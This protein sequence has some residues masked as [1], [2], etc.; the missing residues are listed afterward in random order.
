MHL[1]PGGISGLE[2]K[3]VGHG[4]FTKLNR[5]PTK[6]WCQEHNCAANTIYG[7]WRACKHARESKK[8][9][10]YILVTRELHPLV[11][12]IRFGISCY[13]AGTLIVTYIVPK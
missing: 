1:E 2:L 10:P 6:E 11:Q 9:N 8:R 7:H 13:P 12:S 5:P 3:Y 4:G